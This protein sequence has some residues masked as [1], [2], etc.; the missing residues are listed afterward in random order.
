MDSKNWTLTAR[1][2]KLFAAMLRAL[3]SLRLFFILSAL[4]A[5]AM[6]FETLFN[7]G[8]SVYGT[9]WFAGLGL[10][11]AA[12]IAVCSLR[13]I[14]TAP[15][16][17]TLLHLGLVGVIAGAFLTRYTRFEAELPLY[18]GAATDSVDALDG[19]YRL[20]FSVRL[21]DFRLEYYAE[22]Q[23]RLTVWDEQGQPLRVAAQPGA[24]VRTS[25]G[26]TVTVRQTRKDFGL[27]ARREAVE[28]SP[29]W[30][31]PAAQVEVAS[32]ADTRAFWVFSNFSGMGAPASPV[33]LS[34]AVEGAE[35][36]DFISRVTIR[37]AGGEETRGEIRVNRPLKHAGYTLYQTSYDPA[38]A[39]YTLLTV[40]RVRGLW[41]VYSGFAAL[42]LGVGLWLRR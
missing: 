37:S 38:D 20:P 40:T 10:A 15:T 34:Y 36:R 21:E 32:G 1:A 30:N 17:F 3:S 5:A 27:N 26:V 8:A 39:G 28:K 7:R 4:L 25:G 29:Y 13:R 2:D 31:N 23:G 9:A 24:S 33:R 16:H 18:S 11:L 19:I 35:I 14:R 22:P 42:L 12:N 6:L 41:M